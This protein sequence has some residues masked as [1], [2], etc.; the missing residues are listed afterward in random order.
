LAVRPGF[1]RDVGLLD[2]LAP[3]GWS[4]PQ[5]LEPGVNDHVLAI[6]ESI[7]SSAGLAAESTYADWMAVEYRCPL[8]DRR[9]ME[10][11]MSIPSEYKVGPRQERYMFRSA[12]RGDVPSYVL[13]RDDKG[14]GSPHLRTRLRDDIARLRHAFARFQSNSL[15]NSMIDLEKV[16]Q[17][18]ADIESAA[19]WET[20]VWDLN[21]VILP[22]FL[23]DF[24][25]RHDAK[26]E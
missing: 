15:W 11:F 9:L 10:A 26:V 18:L 3:T 24:L 4:Y 25:E 12:L 23:G 16:E 14:P 8:Y 5:R 19:R 2:Y 20:S 22:Y 1:A 7:I 6:L 21:L 13:D 17:G